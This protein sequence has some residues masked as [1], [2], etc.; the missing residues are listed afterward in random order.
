MSAWKMYRM[1][2]IPEKGINRRGFWAEPGQLTGL[3]GASGGGKTTML[4]LLLSLLEPQQGTMKLYAG[5]AG[6]DG[7][8]QFQKDSQTLPLSPATRQL[9][10]YVPQGNAMFSGT[11]A[12]NMR[13][14]KPDATDKEIIDCLKKACAWEFIGQLP[15]TIYEKSGNAGIIFQKGRHSAFPLQG[16]CLKMHRYCSSMKPLRHSTLKRKNRF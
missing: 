5:D 6:Q 11:I 12:D 15:D 10:A 13:S 16:H 2:I 8:S 7:N 3:V 9:Y 1:H 14:V 4:R